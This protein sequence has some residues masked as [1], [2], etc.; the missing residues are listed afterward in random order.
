MNDWLNSKVRNCAFYFRCPDHR[1]HVY[2]HWQ[3]RK[4]GEGEMNPFP[5]HIPLRNNRLLLLLFYLFVCKRMYNVVLVWLQFFFSL[6]HYC[7]CASLSVFRSCV[8]I[9][10]KRK[11]TKIHVCMHMCL[12]VKFCSCPT[13]KDENRIETK[14][15]FIISIKWTFI[16]Y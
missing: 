2:T 11:D 8:V 14:I 10:N 1:Y 3:C 16:S 13:P 6:F 15:L 12:Y 9:L 5:L 7:L 4:H